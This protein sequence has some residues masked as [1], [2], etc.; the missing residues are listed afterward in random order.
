MIQG[1][2][3]L[4][5]LDPKK[6][7]PLQSWEFPP[8]GKVRIGRAQDN[9]VVLSNDLVSRYHLELEP[10]PH[11]TDEA[12]AWRVTNRGTNGTLVN[13]Q[14]ISQ[15][16]VESKSLIQLAAGGPILEL[17]FVNQMIALP[18]TTSGCTHEGNAPNNLFCI[19]C[20]QPLHVEKQVRDYRI[21]R[22]LGQGGMGT[23]YLAYPPPSKKNSSPLIVLKEMNS[24]LARIAKA[25]ELFDR[26]ARTLKGLNH[27]GIP[28][29]FDSFIEEGKKYL[30][31]ELIH[32]EDLERLLYQ[33]G[34]FSAPV[35]IELMIQTCQILGYLH[36]QSPP[37]VHRDIK[38]A[39]LLLRRLDRQ[40]VVIDF[41]AV[42]EIGTPLGTRIG[43]EG[44]S[45]PEQDR[46]QPVTQSDLYAIGPTL[47]FLL[48]GEQPLKYY[49]RRRD[50]S[51]RLDLQSVGALSPPLRDVI[52]KTTAPKPRDRF[53]NA[54]RLAQAL[55]SALS[56]IT[57]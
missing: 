32:G 54:E 8:Q 13:H 49:K 27:P 28:R 56:A 30:A 25:R 3:A 50:L 55:D 29:F 17:T 57:G 35:A 24:D 20:G 23:T 47:V 51:Y 7:E 41:G 48:T 45:A 12:I 52:E 19:H 37:I 5:L 33:Q 6:G 4:T 26:E 21:L 42:K 18:P 40:I 14:A 43:A 46:G 1:T 16:I 11:Q 10:I 31:M 15:M 2:I 44:Y 34:P 22:I 39:N 53:P 36:S 38:P 9:E